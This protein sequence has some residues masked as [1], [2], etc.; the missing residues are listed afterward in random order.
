MKILHTSDWHL[1]RNF[2]GA[3]LLDDQRKV[4][5]EIIDLAVGREVDLVVIAGDIYDRA[6]PP[7]PAVDLFDE[8]LA[9]LHRAGVAVVAIAGNHDSAVRVSVNDR[10]LTAAGVT[11]RGDI[12]RATEPM[13]LHPDDGGGPVAV[14][15]VPFL[16]PLVVAS[17]F[18]VAT[19]GRRPTHDEATRA[20][21]DLIRDDLAQRR[22]DLPGLRSVLVAH[23]FVTGAKTTDSER[24]LTV[25]HQ[26][27]VGLEALA[28]F[29]YVALGHLHRPQEPDGPRVVYSGSPLPYSFSE[30]DH[31]KSV[32]LVE[33][34][35]DGSVDL[36]EVPLSAGRRLATIEGELA[37]LL[38][39]PTLTPLEDAFVRVHLTDRDLP[40][41]AMAR[42]RDRFPLAVELRHVPPVT[43]GAGEDPT[44]TRIGPSVSPLDLVRRFWVAHEERE[45]DPDQER[46]VL[47]ALEATMAGGGGER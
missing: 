47:E 24:E 45:L 1:G 13:V 35:S 19:E 46:V 39:D 15:P 28:G 20:V 26:E 31:T 5:A 36:E 6:I 32:R 42:I 34:H 10:V 11:V 38:D 17:E 37:E 14:Y 18:E 25:G 16:E 44:A 7:A 27:M 23:T 9:S 4:V 8:A 29:H 43:A 41:Q 22:N 33:L 2:H 40:L 12:V 3:S 30:Q 21:C